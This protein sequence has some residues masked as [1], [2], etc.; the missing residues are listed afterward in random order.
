MVIVTKDLSKE[1][2]KRDHHVLKMWNRSTYILS[3]FA[4]IIFLFGALF[5]ST[6]SNKIKMECN[7]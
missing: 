2:V 7:T 4:M 6:K 1:Y 5:S 3:T